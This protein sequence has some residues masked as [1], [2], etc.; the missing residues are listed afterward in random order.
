MSFHP[1]TH[2]PSVM[3]E[4][5]GI[6]LVPSHHSQGGC[7]T[8]LLESILRCSKGPRTRDRFF[9][10]PTHSRCISFALCANFSV[11]S[12][13]NLLF[14]LRTAIVALENSEKRALSPIFPPESEDEINTGI[15]HV[16]EEAEEFDDLP[17]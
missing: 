15:A 12:F 17:A 5:Q 9:F 6:F 13:E 16:G 10:D 8:L 1:L 2:P 11:T 4:G 3:P 7:S 14:L